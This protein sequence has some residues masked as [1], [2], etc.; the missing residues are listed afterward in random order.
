MAKVAGAAAYR[1]LQRPSNELGQGLQRWGNV[2]VQQKADEKLAAERKQIRDEKAR[3][4]FQDKLA[5]EFNFEQSMSEDW[6]MKQTNLAYEGSQ[7]AAEWSREATRLWETDRGKAMEYQRMV[8]NLENS[9]KIESSRQKQIDAMMTKVM[10]NRDKYLEFDPRFQIIDGVIMGR[11]VPT[12]GK[13]GNIMYVIQLDHNQDGV[14]SEEEQSVFDEY[15]RQGYKVSDDLSYVIAKSSD[16]ANG[17]VLPYE[18]VDILGK[19]GLVDKLTHDVGVST[20]D[21]NTG[22]FVE[23]TSEITQEQLDSL[24]KRTLIELRDNRTMAT[25]MGRIMGVT[26]RGVDGGEGGWTDEDREAAAEELMKAVYAKYPKT[27]SLKFHGNESANKR[28][29]DNLKLGYAKLAQN[30]KHFYDQLKAAKEARGEGED[31]NQILDMFSDIYDRAHQIVEA[32]GRDHEEGRKVARELGVRVGTEF[33]DK[34]RKVAGIKIRGASADVLAAAIAKD[35]AATGYNGVLA[36]KAW[37][38]NGGANQNN[39]ETRT[40]GQPSTPTTPPSREELEA[41]MDEMGL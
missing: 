32:F 30:D 3:Q 21:K 10:E 2:I 15:V 33:F 28:A 5:V 37:E 18:A 29:A 20:I 35:M 34:N 11:T 31:D 27:Q 23:T 13:D 1:Q 25:V 40:T 22:D 17:S 14:V 16:I 6:N 38:A 39:N 19:G 26:N 24:K 12:F 9:F 7:L 36:K 41:Y 4:E 8:K